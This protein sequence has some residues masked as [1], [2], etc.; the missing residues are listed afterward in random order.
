MMINYKCEECGE[1]AD[2]YDEN[3]V[4][5]C[6]AC[7]ESAEEGEEEEVTIRMEMH[8]IGGT[9]AAILARCPEETCFAIFAKDELTANVF[10]ALLSAMQEGRLKI[11]DFIDTEA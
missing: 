2:G 11:A 3:L 8:A 6:D 9:R 1:Q 7:A 5:L 10:K 4:P